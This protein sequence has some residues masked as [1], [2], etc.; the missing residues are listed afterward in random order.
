MSPPVVQE[1]GNPWQILV[2]PSGQLAYVSNEQTA[3]VTIY[4]IGANGAL[5]LYS[6]VAAGVGA[7]G[8][9]VAR[10]R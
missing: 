1:L 10:Q 5:N 8:L 7:G 4:R 9:G 2:D 6:S 3:L